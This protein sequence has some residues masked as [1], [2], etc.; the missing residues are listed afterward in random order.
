MTVDNCTFG[1]VMVDFCQIN[2]SKAY[3]DICTLFESFNQL[4]PTYPWYEQIIAVWQLESENEPDKRKGWIRS[5]N[6]SMLRK[7]KTTVAGGKLIMAGA[8]CLW[9]VP[10][11]FYQQL[12]SRTS[13][14]Q[15]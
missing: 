15:D 7:K 4:L 11:S 1:K 6:K 10:S 9:Y 5:K 13:N 2:V 14:N 12:E 8:V 3:V